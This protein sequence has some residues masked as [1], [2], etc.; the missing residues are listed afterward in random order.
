[1]TGLL[2]PRIMLLFVIFCFTVNV[3]S[4]S[5]APGRW[6]KEI[7]GSGWKLWLDHAAVWRNDDIYL[8]PVDVSSL[9]VNP[10]TCGWDNLDTEY[11]KIV[12]VPG[13]VEEHFWGEIGGVIPD[14]G[15]DYCGVSWWSTAFTLGPDL[16]GKKIT[17]CFE[18]VNLRAE[19][20]VNRTLVGYDVIGNTQFEVDAT[21]VVVFGRENRI[22]VRI[23]DPVGN[24]SWND[25][26]LMRWGENLIPAVH[27][28]GGV[29]GKVVVK[30]T[31]AVHVDD[32]YVQNKPDPKK[33]EVFV[34][35][36]NSSG[37]SQKGKMT[38]VIHEWQKPSLVVWEKSVSV[39]VPPE[40]TEISMNVNAPKAKLW[41]LA[42]HRTFKAANL[43][44]A[45]VVFI[46]DD[47]TI[48]DSSSQ[49]FGFRFFTVGVKN[50]D[51]RFYLNGKRVVIIAAMTRG[52]W[53]KNGIF[54]TPEMA[55]RDME[56][57]V[58][59]GYNMMLL[60]RAIGQPPVMDYADRM[61]LLTYEE[62]GG[63]QLLDNREDNIKEPD[64]QARDLRRIKLERM[65]IRDRSLPSMIIYNLINEARAA[66]DADNERNMRMVHELDPSRILTYNSD[67][68]R[69]IDYTERID[70]DPFKLHMLPFD[71]TFYYHGW[72]DQHHWYAYAG[73]ADLNYNNPRYYLRG[74]VDA[75]TAPVPA[76]SLNRLQE[77]EIIF[78][79]EEGAFGTM[80]RLEKI[81]EELE[82]TGATGFRELEHIDWF[83]A[84]DRFLDDSGFRRSY[85]TVDDLTMSLGRNM[86]YFHGRNIEN[87]RMSNIADGYNLNGWGSG[88]TRT[89]IVDMYRNPTA[90]PSILQYYTQPLYVAV[91]IRDKVLP[92][93]LVPVVDFW[94]IN[95]T[96]L[97]GRNT[98]EIALDNPA[99]ETVFAK[100]FPVNIKG[101]EEFGQLLVE[102]VQLP[103][104]TDTG[105]YMLNARITNTGI[106]KATG[107]DNIFVVDY[108]RGG[109][110]PGRLAVLE[111][112]STVKDFLK[113][114]RGVTVSD[115][116]PGMP[117]QDYIIV[118][119]HDFGKNGENDGGFYDD[120]MKR[121]VAGTNLI[122]LAN[123][124][125][126]A[127]Q[128]NRI[129]H[130]KP[131]TYEG[132]GIS[133]F[134]NSGRYFVG[135]SKYLAGLPVSQ[136]MGWEYQFFY[137]TSNV[138]GI[139]LHHY[140]TELI[141]ALGGQ[142]TKEIVSGL[143]RIQLGQG[144]IFLS[145][146]DFIPGLASWK[147]QASVAKKLFLNLIEISE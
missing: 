72:W 97:R 62:P 17:I 143:S 111:S 142:G 2:K 134:R 89:D 74:V 1:M 102:E 3:I 127:E 128:L 30:A 73:Y 44:E 78:W 53:P 24:F 61:G 9:P 54:A 66:P 68:N 85:P 135:D 47:G 93:G 56:A 16:R 132:G 10:P 15:G 94:I 65:V 81:K 79:G 80:V 8:P 101:G 129:S 14:V 91:K 67:R 115:Y 107:Y 146:M 33:A 12:D 86:H 106:E 42:G 21:G 90:D 138:S 144:Q 29:T 119:E 92:V 121:V 58:D 103:A 137:T 122:V 48:N 113:T 105:H 123:V 70:P 20:F 52:F 34:T 147:P 60:H 98:L 100:E 120:I 13:T 95:E 131:P 19:I 51:K 22:D 46:D 71:D 140:G 116:K 136:S 141:V 25:N 45:S 35:I 118:G 50:G 63:Y 59:L 130:S 83:N 7:S 37:A 108:M 145:T 114:A 41:E 64:Q 43:Y 124:D 88:S 40:G 126:W 11:D 76:D 104:V 77:D 39:T 23:T 125:Q 110:L 99:G 27:G 96:N 57:L 28:F 26:I 87:V 84:Y 133:R 6:E 32:I 4:V 75:P 38:L 112:D 5:A 18:S 69:T 82:I 55:K 36:G 117:E 49:R 109:R 139:R 31:D